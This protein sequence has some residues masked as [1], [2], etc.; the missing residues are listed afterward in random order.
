LSKL[1]EALTRILKEH[2]MTKA[3]LAKVVNVDS[4]YVNRICNG[5]R[6][7]T[8]YALNSMCHV[9]IFSY[10]DRCDIV[11]A[12]IEDTLLLPPI[13]IELIRRCMHAA[14]TLHEL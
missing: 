13:Y 6:L 9:S 11:L 7:P 12:L 10:K 8:W 1:G 14:A 5:K 2:N 4:S 3:G